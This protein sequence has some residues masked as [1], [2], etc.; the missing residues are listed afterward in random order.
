[1]TFLRPLQP[2]KVLFLMTLR[3]D[4]RSIFVRLSQSVKAYSPSSIR[5]RGRE[6][7]L[8]LLHVAK[9]VA[10][11]SFTP[12]GITISSRFLHPSK[13]RFPITAI[14]SGMVTCFL[15]PLYR[16]STPFS[17]LNFSDMLPP[18]RSSFEC[19]CGFLNKVSH[20]GVLFV[21]NLGR[22]SPWVKG[23]QRPVFPIHAVSPSSAVQTEK[24]VREAGPSYPGR[25][26]FPTKKIIKKGLHPAA[27]RPDSQS[28]LLYIR[29]SYI[30]DID[31]ITRTAASQGPDAVDGACSAGQFCFRSTS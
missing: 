26:F 14:P 16:I 21:H 27:S 23:L 4:L 8:S 20:R 7:N 13:A 3:S 25:S 24:T 22:N 29:F 28:P 12:S 9:A 2:S 31:L 10:L 18:C 15:F 5:L 19:S 6:T 17:T 11:I 1:M 30:Y